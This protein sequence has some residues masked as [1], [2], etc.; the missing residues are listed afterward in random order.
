MKLLIEN[1]KIAGLVR[2]SHHQEIIDAPDNF[3]PKYWQYYVINSRGEVVLPKPI[4][5]IVLPEI[6]QI[7]LDKFAKTKGYDDIKSAISYADSSIIKYAEEGQ[8]CKSLRDHC[9]EILEILFEEMEQEI[10]P[11]STDW[12]SIRE[13]FPAFIWP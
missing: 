12:E 1:N 2:N 8:F 4:E 10:T 9:W 11:V 7:E 6:L 3:N 5:R 13:R